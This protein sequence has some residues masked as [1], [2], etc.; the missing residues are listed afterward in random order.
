M[1]CN[2]IC[3]YIYIYIYTYIYTH[4][5]YIYIYIYIC[6]PMYWRL[7]R[8]QIMMLLSCTNVTI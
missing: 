4:I 6:A 8:S 1:Y 5:I 2:N 7:F 3:M